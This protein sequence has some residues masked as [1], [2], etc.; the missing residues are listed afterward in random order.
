MSSNKK[1]KVLFVCLGN[2]CRSP[3]AHG[4]MLH[5]LSQK[6]ISNV[7]VDSCRTRSRHTEDLL[8]SRMRKAAKSRGIEL[9]HRA[10]QL[11]K[12]DY[13]SFDIIVTMD[14]DNYSTVLGRGAPKDKVKKMIDFVSDK[15]G[16]DEIPDPYYGSEDG[17]YLVLDLVDDRCINI[18]IQYGHLN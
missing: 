4:T 7:E 11:N 3:A 14:D 18:L 13:T 8:D 6:G 5:I 1:L 17:L 15:K 9:T 16:N 10:R 2:I 12:S